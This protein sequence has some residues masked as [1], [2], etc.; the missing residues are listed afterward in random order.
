MDQRHTIEFSRGVCQRDEERIRSKM[1][2]HTWRWTR[3]TWDLTGGVSKITMQRR[4]SL[5]LAFS[6]FSD[7]E[8]FAEDTRNEFTAKSSATHED[9][10]EERLI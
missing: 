4:Y 2:C 3:R 1:K 6:Y 7:A 5:H 9:S 8:K 10:S